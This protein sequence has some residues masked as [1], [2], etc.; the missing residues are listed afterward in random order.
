LQYTLFHCFVVFGFIIAVFCAVFVLAMDSVL[1]PVR[2]KQ[3]MPKSLIL[4]TLL[5][6]SVLAQ[7]FM[8]GSNLV[9]MTLPPGARGLALAGASTAANIDASAIYYNPAGLTSIETSS[10]NIDGLA[11]PWPKAEFFGNIKTPFFNLSGAYNIPDAGALGVSYAYHKFEAKDAFGGNFS[12]SEYLV[13]LGFARQLSES[14]S[15]GVAAK[16]GRVSMRMEA[17]YLSDIDA[18][19]GLFALDLGLLFHDATCQPILGTSMSSSGLN[20]GLTLKEIGPK[21]SFFDGQD[22][23]IPTNMRLGLSYDWLAVESVSSTVTVDLVKYLND[24]NVPDKTYSWFSAFING[25][26]D[27]SFADELR[28]VS[29]SAGLEIRYRN[30]VSFRFGRGRDFTPAINTWSVGIGGRY[31]G[32]G[33][34]AVYI[35]KK[36]LYVGALRDDTSNGVRFTLSYER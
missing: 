4:F 32:F 25:W 36:Y 27:Q 21:Y 14:F 10:L 5:S 23:A 24:G 26:T 17:G 16:F 1:F 35:T 12:S 22:E 2:N 11:F 30:V 33:L 3:R 29:Y 13:T 19:A 8:P 31:S 20:L 7:Q 18:S 9:L 6:S 28:H 15:G 34:D